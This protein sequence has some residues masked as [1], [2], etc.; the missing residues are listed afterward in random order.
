VGDNP[1]TQYVVADDG[2]RLAY[3]VVGE[4]V[5]NVVFDA[6]TSIS[7]DLMWENP[8][9]VRVGRYL[10]TFCRSIWVESRGFGASGGTRIGPG[11]EACDGDLLAVLDAAGCE[12]VVLLGSSHGGKNA[13]R[14]AAAHSERV[15]ALVLFNSFAHYLRHDDYPCGMPAEAMDRFVDGTKQSWG[16]GEFADLVAPSRAGDGRFRQWLAR[17]ERLGRGPDQMA[18]MV[19]GDFAVDVRPLLPTIAVPT[20]VVH[21]RGNRYIRVGAGRYLAEHIPGAKYVELPG[22]DHF[23][24]VGDVDAWIEEVEEFLTGRRQAADGDVVLATVLF[25]DIVDSTAR[26]A[27]LGHRAWARLADA[28]DLL[29]REAIGRHGGR[30]VKTLGDGFLVVFDLT[31]R[32]VRCA[33]EIVAQA[34]EL[35]LELRAGLH[36]GEVE[37]RNDDVAGLAVTIAKRICDLAD[38]RQVLTSETIKEHI[39]GTGIALSE[40]GA[41]VLKGVPDQWRL[42][43]VGE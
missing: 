21:R 25:T 30:A 7:I 20:L 28:H 26:E 3:Q 8:G 36:S 38:P 19:A 42:F 1:V 11:A 34:G 32:A 18:L 23:F 27:A 12:Q 14:F 24:F 17:C 16:T 13:V 4:G 22:D 35:G 37:V 33:Q 2:A 6:G 9:V 43:I 29:V 15:R 31:T 39:V 41:H 40:H 10:S 5:L